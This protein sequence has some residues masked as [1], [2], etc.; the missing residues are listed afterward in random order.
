MEFKRFAMVAVIIGSALL[1]GD[2]ALHPRLH[3]SLPSFFGQFALLW[4]VVF[5][6]FPA[7]RLLLCPWYRIL[8][9]L[10]SFCSVALLGAVL[11]V[12]LTGAPK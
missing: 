11:A 3:F 1:A 6:R 12:E 10:L 7:M 9:L 5:L 4:L 2:S 8:R